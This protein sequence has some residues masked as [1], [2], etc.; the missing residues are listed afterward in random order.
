MNS[1]KYGIYEIID[2]FRLKRKNV[3]LFAVNKSY[4]WLSCRLSGE[5]L[6]FYKDTEIKAKKGDVLYIPKKCSYSQKTQEEEIVCMHL[7][8]YREDFDELTIL[9][10]ES[11]EEI[12]QLFDTAEKLWAKKEKNYYFNCLSI[13]YKILS[14]CDL[15][16][17]TLVSPKTEAFP[18]AERIKKALEYLSVN[19]FSPQLSV[20]DMYKTV[21]M[22][23][24]DFNN[25]FKKI[26]GSTPRKYIYHERINRVK[27]LLKTQN[28]TNEEIAQLC[29]FNDV[30]YMYVVF[31]KV[32]G[33]STKE[34][35]K[36]RN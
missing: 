30:K 34:Y 23:R 13:L 29:G 19:L 35:L 7:N 27:T 4:C 12:C 21:H 10:S 33:M 14:L 25:I 1:N 16:F 36:S 20:T 11:Y 15:D 6:F 9:K 28:Y 24:T 5:G 18:E 31:K 26:Y 3:K 2:I 32:T 22:G 8:T 17:S